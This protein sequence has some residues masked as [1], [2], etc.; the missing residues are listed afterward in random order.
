MTSLR[1]S[2]LEIHEDQ[3]PD[4]KYASAAEIDQ[5]PFEEGVH[6]LFA[7]SSIPQAINTTL[8]MLRAISMRASIGRSEN[9]Q[10]SGT[11]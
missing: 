6:R 1:V 3:R 2:V 9:A 11:K 8:T 10:S 4:A 5:P 7:S